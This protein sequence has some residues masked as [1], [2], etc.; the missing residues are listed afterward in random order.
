MLQDTTTFLASLD[1]SERVMLAIAAIG[2]VGFLWA[3]LKAIQ[4][5]RTELRRR[6]FEGPQSYDGLATIGIRMY[7]AGSA[8]CGAL[9]GVLVYLALTAG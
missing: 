4:E 2:V 1:T 7:T 5:L 3:G 9:A 6:K 8:V